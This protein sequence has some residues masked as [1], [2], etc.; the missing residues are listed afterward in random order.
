MEQV[1]QIANQT[2]SSYKI[3][4]VGSLNLSLLLSESISVLPS[5]E[6]VNET[7]WCDH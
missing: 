7:L 1:A 3:V 2:V 6:S 4:H 5:F